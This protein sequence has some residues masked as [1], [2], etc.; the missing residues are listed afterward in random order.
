MQESSSSWNCAIQLFLPFSIDAIVPGEGEGPVA[1]FMRP[2]EADD[3]VEA[4]L[5]LILAALLLFVLALPLVM[6][7]FVLVA[8]FGSH[9]DN[10]S[11]KK[12]SKYFAFVNVFESSCQN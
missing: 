6:F 1:I 4:L 8:K 5:L 12:F 9:L 7:E 3:D 11:S 2:G 10:C